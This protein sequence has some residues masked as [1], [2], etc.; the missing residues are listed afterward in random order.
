MVW[1]GQYGTQFT[2]DLRNKKKDWLRSY[3]VPSMDA[4]HGRVRMDCQWDFFITS[5][6]LINFNVTPKF[7]LYYNNERFLFPSKGLIDVVHTRNQFFP[8]M[9][10]S[11][12]SR[13]RDDESEPS[14]VFM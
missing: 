13:S 14:V 7:S 4:Q 1:D 2:I 10:F 8:W 5:N 6:K 9:I 12:S 11:G 3:N